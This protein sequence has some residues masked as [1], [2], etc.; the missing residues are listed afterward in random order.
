[1]KELKR[2]F[3]VD[4]SE[5]FRYLLK[6]L[7]YIFLVPF[8]IFWG[9][10]FFTKI[11]FDDIYYS[12]SLLETVEASAS[13]QASA[14]ASIQNL[15]SNFGISIPS[16]ENDPRQIS[17]KVIFSQ[18][19]FYRILD[20]NPQIITNL[21]GIESYDSV[22][23]QIV[24]NKYTPDNL[25]SLSEQN[26]RKVYLCY[27][28]AIIFN[29]DALSGLV[30]LTL[31]SL[32]PYAS[33]ESLKLLLNEFN[34]HMLVKEKSL[35]ESNLIFL[36]KKLSQ[37][38]LNQNIKQILGNTYQSQFQKYTMTE[39]ND[40]YFLKILVPP[41]FEIRKSEPNRLIMCIISFILS[42]LGMIVFFIYRYF[43][44]Q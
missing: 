29:I 21:C 38:G 43:Q 44:K 5:V 27:K 41:S 14:S 11:Y 39:I 36:E 17:R 1:M 15:A 31:K 23:Q 40:E 35:I 2:E 16:A 8:I 7:L 18:D 32:S 12:N 28:A 25:L 42:F 30:E 4:V 19:F 13:P 33:R 10:Y 34:K 24:Y 6:R 22:S 3:E 9:T 37:P 26:K 20:N